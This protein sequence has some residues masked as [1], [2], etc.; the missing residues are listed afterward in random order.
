MQRLRWRES[1]LRQSAPLIT[2]HVYEVEIR[3]DSTAYIFP[4]GHKIRFT[5]SSAAAPYYNPTSNTGENDM[6]KTVEPVVAKNTL[7]FGPQRPSRVTL[8]VVG[9]EAIPKNAHFTGIG[10]FMP[11]TAERVLI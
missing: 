6:V 8:P 3:L 7:Y 9:A 2:D 1:E 10:P 4:K 5:V 11:T